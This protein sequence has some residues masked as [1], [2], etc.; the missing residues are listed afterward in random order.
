MTATRPE[1]WARI[2]ARA[3]AL[4]ALALITSAGTQIASAADE[5]PANDVIVPADP[6]YALTIDRMRPTVVTA[7]LGGAPSLSELPVAAEPQPELTPDLLASYIARQQE[8]K[9][10]D[11]FGVQTEPE[12]TPE[13]LSAYIERKTNPALEAIDAMALKPSF[14]EAPKLNGSVLEEYASEKYVPTPKKVKLA[15]DERLCLTQAIYHEARGES[16]EGQWAVGNVIINRAFS[17]KFPTTI[18]GVVFQNVRKGSRACQ[19]SFACDGRSDMGKDQRAWARSE[20]IADTAFAEFQMGD[21]P[22]VVPQDTLYYHT[23]AVAPSWSRTFQ[24]V[25]AIGAHLFYAP[26]S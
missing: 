3:V 14:G 8:L 20:E 6:S 2:R 12:L 15:D 23:R 1:T 4:C 5:T 13:V 25:A 9:T 10:F 7:S 18:C 17:K 22:D 16:E 11:H 19:F 24:R 26:N 21:R